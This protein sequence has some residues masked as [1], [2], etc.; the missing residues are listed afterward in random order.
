[1]KRIQVAHKLSDM[2]VYFLRTH[3]EDAKDQLYVELL[4]KLISAL[5]KQDLISFWQEGFLADPEPCTKIYADTHFASLKEIQTINNIIKD[6]MM[7][8]RV[9]D[10]QKT[11]KKLQKLESIINDTANEK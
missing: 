9:K 3:G 4:R 8:L 5:R 6:I 7:D 1:M 11:M 2:D 10:M